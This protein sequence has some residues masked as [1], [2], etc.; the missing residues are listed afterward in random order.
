MS[1]AD[2]STEGSALKNSKLAGDR[3]VALMLGKEPDAC[4][5]QPEPSQRKERKVELVPEAVVP[6][7][8]NKPIPGKGI[9]PVSASPA[10]GVKDCEVEMNAVPAVL[11]RNQSARL[12]SAAIATKPSVSGP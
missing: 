5:T 9:A 4:C 2:S 6:S 3:D 7:I 11:M 8:C 1:D 10:L 12:P